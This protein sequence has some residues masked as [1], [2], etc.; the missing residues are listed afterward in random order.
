MPDQQNIHQLRTP[1]AK[2]RQKCAWWAG[3]MP[4][5]VQKPGKSAPGGSYQRMRI[6]SKASFKASYKIFAESAESTRCEIGGKVRL[7]GRFYA[8][9][10]AKTRQKCPWCVWVFQFIVGFSI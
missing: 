7:V 1:G 2:T 8:P 9:P 4:H 6:L 5:Q 3:F 10:G